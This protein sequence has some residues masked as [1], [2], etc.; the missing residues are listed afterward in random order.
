MKGTWIKYTTETDLEC[1]YLLNG[2]IKET[3]VKVITKV[4]R[5][6]YHSARND[7]LEYFEK[8]IIPTL[9]GQ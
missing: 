9:Q 7:A 1:A 5:G 3:R 4:P 6:Q 2:I 8:H